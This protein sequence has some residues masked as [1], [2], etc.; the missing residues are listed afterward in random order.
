MRERRGRAALCAGCACGVRGSHSMWSLCVSGAPVAAAHGSSTQVTHITL[1]L[2]L[3]TPRRVPRPP[4]PLTIALRPLVTRVVRRRVS[5]ERLQTGRAVSGLLAWVGCEAGITYLLTP[6]SLS[7]AAVRCT[8][9]HST[10]TVHPPSMPRA[11]LRIASL[12]AASRRATRRARTARIKLP[13]SL[14]RPSRPRP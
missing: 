7:S 5:G 2:R 13:T 12:A 6:R 14:S 1:R 10:R 8:Y 11:A 9:R 4:R 3:L